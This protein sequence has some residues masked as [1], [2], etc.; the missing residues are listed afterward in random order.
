MTR[1]GVGWAAEEDEEVGEEE[2]GAQEEEEQ[3]PADLQFRHL[4]DVAPHGSLLGAAK[5]KVDIGSSAYLA[6][7]DQQPHYLCLSVVAAVCGGQP[8][9][10][11]HQVDRHQQQ[12]VHAD[13]R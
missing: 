4:K 11:G 3:Q 10:G 2:A 6:W 12:A 5:D 7:P 8:G 1:V 13:W 9:G